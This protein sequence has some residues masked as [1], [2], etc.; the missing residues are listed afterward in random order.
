MHDLVKQRTFLCQN[1]TSFALIL[2]NKEIKSKSDIEINMIGLQ[3]NDKARVSINLPHDPAIVW[4]QSY[5]TSDNENIGLANAEGTIKATFKE[6]PVGYDM[7]YNI[8]VF[9]DNVGS[10]PYLIS[11][12]KAI[13]IPVPANEDIIAK[14]LDLDISKIDAT[15]TS[16]E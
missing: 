10:Q 2:P 13:P 6:V 11:S 1:N 12:E 8:S 5:L 14:V 15:S 7:T 16:E 4:S 9:P 3:P